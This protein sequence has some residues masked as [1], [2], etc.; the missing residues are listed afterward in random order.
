MQLAL[1]LG[2]HLGASYF[3]GGQLLQSETA[4]LGCGKGSIKTPC[5]WC[6]PPSSRKTFEMMAAV[7]IRGLIGDKV[8][9][10]A[11]EK[12]RR[13][14]G[15][16]AAHIYGYLEGLV[17]AACQEREIEC[18]PI[19]V[20]TWKS[21]IGT[22]GGGKPAYIARVNELAGLALTEADEDRAASVGIGFAAFGLPT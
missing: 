5:P 13:H 7:T 9:Q 10:V 1:D 17:R 8:T 18:I 6:G 16:A 3:A 11:Y 2:Q 15:V 20:A 19:D 14:Q 21:R 4:G 22:K 12:V